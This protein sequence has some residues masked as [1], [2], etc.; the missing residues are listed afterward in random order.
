MDTPVPAAQRVSCH[1][2]NADVLKPVPERG[3]LQ[4]PAAAKPNR[5]KGEQGKAELA[6]VVS[7]SMTGRSYSKGK[8]LGKVRLVLPVSRAFSASEGGLELCLT[9]GRGDVLQVCLL[10]RKYDLVAPP[11]EHHE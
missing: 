6:Q 7:D 11:S 1:A 9:G 4:P 5:N 10:M 2:M 8:L 3:A